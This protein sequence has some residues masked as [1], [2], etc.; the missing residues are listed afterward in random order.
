MQVQ[1]SSSQKRLR[2]LSLFGGQGRVLNRNC[3]GQKETYGLGGFPIGPHRKLP[4]F[5]GILEKSLLEK[6]R[7]MLWNTFCL[8][9]VR[10]RSEMHPLHG[11]V[12]VRTQR[13]I[14]MLILCV[15]TAGSR[16]ILCFRTASSRIILCVGA[17]SSGITLCLRTVSSR[18]NSCV[19]TSGGRV[20]L[21]VHTA[22]SRIILCVRTVSSRIILCVR[23]GS[24]RIILCVYTAGSCVVKPSASAQ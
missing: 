20:I 18:I 8:K 24:S 16:I 3:L 9:I 15:C 6:S 4:I 19:C 2:S 22:S 13:I 14:R 23:T 10:N 12:T 21:C 7:L 11:P 17:V 5:Q 1:A